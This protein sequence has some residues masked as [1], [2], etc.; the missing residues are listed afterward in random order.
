MLK[1]ID[2]AFLESGHHLGDAFRGRSV[3]ALDRDIDLLS[4]LGIALVKTAERRLVGGAEGCV[5]LDELVEVGDQPCVCRMGP[6]CVE[7]G[8]Q[9]LL[10]NLFPFQER[11]LISRKFLFLIT[12]DENIF[13][14]AYPVDSGNYYG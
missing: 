13:P 14:Y 1:M 9:P 3:P 6:E 11:L 12:T 10:N 8:S 7:R 5:I 4:S 2:F